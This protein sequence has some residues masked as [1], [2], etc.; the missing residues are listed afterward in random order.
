MYM[1]GIYNFFAFPNINPY[2]KTVGSKRRSKQKV[3][4]RDIQ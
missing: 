1:R 3:G 4:K 2:E